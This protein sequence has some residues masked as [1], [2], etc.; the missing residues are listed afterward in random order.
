MNETYYV[1]YI[2]GGDNFNSEQE[3][4]SDS[5]TGFA[6]TL[7]SLLKNYF[8]LIILIFILLLLYKQIAK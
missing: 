7:Q 5:N 2:V 3:T 4:E 8:P 1:Y 6:V